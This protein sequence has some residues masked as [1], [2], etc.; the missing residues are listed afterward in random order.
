MLL[1][2]KV[3]TLLWAQ[4]VVP[5]D[6]KCLRQDFF[7]EILHQRWPKSKNSRVKSG[8][9]AINKFRITLLALHSF[10]AF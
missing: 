5:I 7:S 8:A 2:L 9:D 3:G 1:R 6:I 10:E 4:V